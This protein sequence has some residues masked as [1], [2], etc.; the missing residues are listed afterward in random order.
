MGKLDKKIE[1]LIKSI[2]K[3]TKKNKKKKT[4]NKKKNKL[5]VPVKNPFLTPNLNAPPTSTLP[6][7][8][9]LLIAN[10]AKK[11][12]EDLQDNA[13]AQDKIKLKQQLL[14]IEDKTN[15]TKLKIKS[16]ED[17]K[18][19]FEKSLI[20]LHQNQL[21]NGYFFSDPIQ[22]KDQEE[23]LQLK[24][25]KDILS[26]RLKNSKSEKEIDSNEE[27]LQNVTRR[28]YDKQAEID[29]RNAEIQRKR[30]I[31]MG[32]NRAR[33]EEENAAQ[34]LKTAE[35]Q[36]RK[37]SKAAADLE[38]KIQKAAEAKAHIEKKEKTSF[39]KQAATNLESAVKALKQGNLVSNIDDHLSQEWAQESTPAVKKRLIKVP[40][41]TLPIK[42]I[43][44]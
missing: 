16:I 22:E 38:I 15:E 2:N 11:K 35:K 32:I 28:L 30:M 36:G 19:Q 1:K 3:L 9:S 37:A 17:Y 14:A 20:D 7:N 31:T 42:D 24:H 21:Q 12:I 13:I 26:T 25:E 43:D 39:E 44:L 18:K 41:G 8:T 29:S 23:V 40:V 27:E 6:N 5:L 10:D 34:I 33:K 4:K